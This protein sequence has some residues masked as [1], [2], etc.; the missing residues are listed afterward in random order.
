MIDELK[1]AIQKSGN[2]LHFKV[3]DFLQQSGWT[4]DISCYYLDDATGKPREI[5]II[6]KQ[7]ITLSESVWSDNPRDFWVY[8]FYR[9]QALR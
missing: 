6:A 2:N 5:D 3:L 7:K 4:A 1:N 8:L 9:V